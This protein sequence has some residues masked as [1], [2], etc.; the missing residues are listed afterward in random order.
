MHHRNLTSAFL[1]IVSSPFPRYPPHSPTD[2][3]HPGIH[4]TQDRF[5][6]SAF[7]NASQAFASCTCALAYLFVEKTRKGSKGG[8][9]TMVGWKSPDVV[10]VDGSAS[11]EKINGRN[12]STAG[13]SI[14]SWTQ[15]LPILLLRVGLCQTLGSPIGFMSLKYISYPTMVLAKVSRIAFHPV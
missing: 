13:S 2:A 1:F 4:T 12:N 5:P 7:I 8:F 6:S 14:L 9:G 11:T 3:E 15:S 10:T